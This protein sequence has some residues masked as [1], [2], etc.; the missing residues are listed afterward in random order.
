MIKGYIYLEHIDDDNC[1]FHS[2]VNIDPKF[3]FVPE[4]LLNFSLK[5]AICVMISK[6]SDK[7]NFYSDIMLERILKK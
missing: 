2:Y 7:E 1:W 3:K 6:I 4:W 5:R